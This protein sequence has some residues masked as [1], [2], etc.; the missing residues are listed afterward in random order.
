MDTP[1]V[2]ETE[3]AAKP[4]FVSGDTQSI[5]ERE[6]RAFVDDIPAPMREEM[7][8]H[9]E[10]ES[11]W[12]GI[13][14]FRHADGRMIWM[15]TLVMPSPDQA[16]GAGNRVLWAITEANEDRARRAES[17]YQ[18]HSWQWLL[19]RNPAVPAL[20][21]VIAGTIAS[22]L[23][24]VDI[25]IP[26]TGATLAGLFACR[27]LRDATT[28]TVPGLPDS[29]AA[30]LFPGRT[31]S[32]DYLY[33]LQRRMQ[34]ALRI[35]LANEHNGLSD[36]LTGT[37]QISKQLHQAHNLASEAFD[38]MVNNVEALS[39]TVAS[40]KHGVEEARTSQQ[41]L[42]RS[43]EDSVEGVSQSAHQTE[44]L[45]MGLTQA[46]NETRNLMDEAEHMRELKSDIA[47]FTDKTD[48]LALNA[49]VEAARAG[50]HG[51]SFTI[52]ADEVREL[53]ERS[54]GTVREIETALDTITQ[55]IGHWHRKLREQHSVADDCMHR[56]HESQQKLEE[57]HQQAAANK[58]MLDTLAMLIQET[59]SQLEQLTQTWNTG[60]E[61]M[62]ALQD[63]LMTLDQRLLAIHD[64]I[65]T[66]TLSEA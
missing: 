60:Q 34:Q 19:P 16:P 44:L 46:L 58:T 33:E 57:S 9:L 53:S 23:L 28:N 64:D 56:A 12:H 42:Q 3:G 10:R 39:E 26:V 38:G 25:I 5:T 52:V 40:S 4:F 24:R 49:S 50:Q 54:Q 29:Q 31:P 17:L 51:K 20:V 7:N 6:L 30:I 21:L 41:Q 65:N 59:R 11:P 14:P 55:L 15:D 61:T 35:R 62:Q 36:K 2:F 32:G 63:L 8:Q 22:F 27:V 66:L 47:R 48:L 1:L 18:R 37:S 13:L 45:E 43:L